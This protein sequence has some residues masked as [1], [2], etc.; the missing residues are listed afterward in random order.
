MTN[1]PKPQASKTIDDVLAR[2]AWSGK[3]TDAGQEVV[4]AG[5]VAEA[6][7]AITQ[8]MLEAL[9]EK[10]RKMSFAEASKDVKLYELATHNHGYNQAILEMESAIKKIGGKTK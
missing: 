9:P 8:A 4:S 5:A 3:Y 2:L 6:T 7:Q 1:T 10:K